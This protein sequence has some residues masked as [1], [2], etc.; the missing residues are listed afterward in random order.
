M[1]TMAEQA[2]ASNL[3]DVVAEEAEVDVP[4]GD[5]TAETAG[6]EVEDAK[7]EGTVAELMNGK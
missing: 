7:A 2:G 3:L 5:M 1:P 4:M 6:V